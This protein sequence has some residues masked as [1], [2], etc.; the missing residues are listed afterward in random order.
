[1]MNTYLTD[2]NRVYLSE[3]ETASKKHPYVKLI[4]LM[5]PNTKVT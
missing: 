1:M 2:R 4:Q 5:Y 3:K